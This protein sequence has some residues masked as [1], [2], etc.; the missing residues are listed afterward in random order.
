MNRGFFLKIVSLKPSSEALDLVPLTAAGSHS[1][2]VELDGVA[3]I[4][5]T[6]LTYIQYEP[7]QIIMYEDGTVSNTFLV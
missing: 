6:F 1:Y 5:Y 3:D 7:S 4:A 2:K